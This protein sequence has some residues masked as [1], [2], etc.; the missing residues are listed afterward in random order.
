MYKAIGEKVKGFVQYNARIVL[1][2]I[3]TESKDIFI[4]QVYIPTYNSSEREIEKVYGGIEKVIEKVK[5]DENLI[6]MGDWNAAVGQ[7][8]LGHIMGN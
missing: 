6:I 5:G 1:D 4:V 8:S 3:E 2:N 7:E